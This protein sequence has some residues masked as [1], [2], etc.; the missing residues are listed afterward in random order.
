MQRTR[1]TKGKKETDLF[2]PFVVVL[3]PFFFD[4]LFLVPQGFQF[5]P[6]LLDL[7]F[8]NLKFVFLEGGDFFGRLV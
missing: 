4:H 5:G 7:R 6:Q 1:E 2:V 3:Y 8:D